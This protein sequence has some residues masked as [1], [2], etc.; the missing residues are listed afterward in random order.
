MTIITCTERSIVKTVVKKVSLDMV[1]SFI[2][3]QNHHPTVT[4]GKGGDKKEDKEKEKM[5]KKEKK[6]QEKEKKKEEEDEEE[7]EK[8]GGNNCKRNLQ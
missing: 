2:H 5:Q 8:Q 7:R 1:G 4:W 6:Q 3:C